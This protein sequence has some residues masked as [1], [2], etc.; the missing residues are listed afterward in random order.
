MD[1][2]LYGRIPY[3]GGAAMRQIEQDDKP[4]FKTYL[5]GYLLSVCLTL[6]AYFLVVKRTAS[7]YRFVL[8]VITA[9]AF[10]QFLV[11]LAYF[12]HISIHSRERWRLIV[13]AFMVSIVSILVFGSI[14]IM[15]NLNYRMTPTEINNYMQ[16]Q[17]SL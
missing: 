13:L 4:K 16:D 2:H 7:D 9:L 1:I 15:N 12:L 8:I 17:D 3:G 6:A 5:S 10:V 14:W 11:Q